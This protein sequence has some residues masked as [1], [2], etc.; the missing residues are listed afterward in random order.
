[1][2]QVDDD[3]LVTER[4]EVLHA[5]N[6]ENEKRL[7]R[8]L[9]RRGA[10]AEQLK[11]LGNSNALQD[12]QLQLNCIDAKLDKSARKYRELALA[13]HL[14]ETVR[15]SYETDRQPETLAEASGYLERLTEGK[16]TRIWTPFGES[17]LCVDLHDGSSMT[18]E[19]LSRGTREQV[20]LSLRFALAAAYGRRG[21]RLPIILDDVFVNFDTFRAKAAA[22][23]IKDLASLGNQLLVFTCHEHIRDMFRDIGVDVREL[24]ADQRSSSARST[25][26]QNGSRKRTRK[27]KSDTGSRSVRPRATKRPK[28]VDVG[29]GKR[30]GHRSKT[31]ALYEDDLHYEDDYRHEDKIDQVASSKAEFKEV[32]AEHYD[33]EYDEPWLEAL[34]PSIIAYPEDRDV[35]YRRR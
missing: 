20:F 27:T 8:L 14:L 33:P 4:I 31:A 21:C 29:N 5:K 13:G 24:G 9:E 17:S 28:F 34:E 10:L 7:K 18:M 19:K 35:D 2:E 11:T 26:S 6:R 25:A 22:D 15:R 1:M 3:E 23:L 30:N 32:Q 12:V 16:Y